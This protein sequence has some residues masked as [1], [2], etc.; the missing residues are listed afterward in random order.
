MEKES[1]GTVRYLTGEESAKVFDACP[2]W[3]RPLVLTARHTGLRKE[4][5]LSLKWHQVDRGTS[6]SIISTT[7]ELSILLEFV[8]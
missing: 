1:P 2:E 7:K 6:R 4:N 8:T 3:L 5:I